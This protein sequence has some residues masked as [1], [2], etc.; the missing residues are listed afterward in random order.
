MRL[1]HARSP[2][3]AT[4]WSGLRLPHHRPASIDRHKPQSSHRDSW[5]DES[6]I[7]I[8]MRAPVLVR[9][10]SEWDFPRLGGRATTDCTMSLAPALSAALKLGRI[11]NLPTVWTNTLVGV[12]LAG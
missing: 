4:S 8:I 7:S 3:C 12:T 2:G 10:G 9:P 5:S 11:S 1:S 6:G